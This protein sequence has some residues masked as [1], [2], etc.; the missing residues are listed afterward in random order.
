M[1]EYKIF[2]IAEVDSH[3]THVAA[4]YMKLYCKDG[5]WY[6][7]A[8]GGTPQAVSAITVLDEGGEPIT[9]PNIQFT[10]GLIAVDEGGVTVVRLSYGDD[11]D[12]IPLHGNEAHS[13]P[14]TLLSLFEAHLDDEDAHGSMLPSKWDDIGVALKPKGDKH[15]LI[16]H[17]S[18][19]D[20][21]TLPDI[22]DFPVDKN[23]KVIGDKD[24]YV[25]KLATPPGE[26]KELYV[27]DTGRI[28]TQAQFP[29]THTLTINIVCGTT[30]VPLSGTIFFFDLPGYVQLYFEGS[31]VLTVPEVTWEVM[32]NIMEKNG[33]YKS[34]MGTIASILGDVTL[35]VEMEFTGFGGSGSQL[36][37]ATGAAKN[38][39]AADNIII[40]SPPDPEENVIYALPSAAANQG[41]ELTVRKGFDGYAVAI[42][43]VEGDEKIFLDNGSNN[44]L[45][46]DDMGDWVT[47]KADGSNWYVI[48]HT[49]NWTLDD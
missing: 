44:T 1:K 35:T 27:D 20:E 41:K 29:V 10:G 9:N 18:V 6:T 49:G 45:T 12:D 8:P 3:E 11:D 47:L 2:Y 34:Y 19:T 25:S 22:N 28:V 40:A 24:V 37:R 30:G 4:G 16:P 43:S 21:Y 26:H 33:H 32:F 48:M 7:L 42:E 23:V 5:V 17:L 46:T 36:T 38:I 39:S 13:E 31:V 15:V 14:F